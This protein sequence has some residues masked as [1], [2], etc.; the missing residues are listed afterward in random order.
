MSCYVMQR[1]DW[2]LAPADADE[3]RRACE[4]LSVFSVDNEGTRDIDDALSFEWDE[5]PGA[6]ACTIGVHVADVASR[7]SCDPPLFA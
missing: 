7:V 3:R 2:A 1:E 6:S 4:H 5:T